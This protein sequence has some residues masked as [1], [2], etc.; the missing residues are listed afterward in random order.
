MSRRGL[1]DAGRWLLV[2]LACAGIAS[3]GGAGAAEPTAIAANFPA[4]A[5]ETTT[6]EAAGWSTERISEAKAWSPED[7]ADRGGHVSDRMSAWR[8]PRGSGSMPRH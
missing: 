3:A 4:K 1:M 8:M 5:F 6:P 7:R 2:A